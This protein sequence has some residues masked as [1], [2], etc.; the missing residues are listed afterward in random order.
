M[1][2]RNFNIGSYPSRPPQRQSHFSLAAS[3]VL[4]SRNGSLIKNDS[5]KQLSSPHSPITAGKL[6]LE[7]VEKSNMRGIKPTIEGRRKGRKDEEGGIGAI[8]V[9]GI[10]MRQEIQQGWVAIPSLH[11]TLSL[12]ESLMRKDGFF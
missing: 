3:S 6:I 9:K 10:M 2:A 1:L 11:R 4:L 7:D 12:P 8:A 5:T